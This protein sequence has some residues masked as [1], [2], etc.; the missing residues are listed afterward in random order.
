MGEDPL[1][2][3][4]RVDDATN[5]LACLEVHK[6][7]VMPRRHIVHHLTNDYDMERRALLRRRDIPRDELE[8]ILRDQF[9]ERQA[10]KPVARQNALYAGT[11]GCGGQGAGGN[12]GS[13]RGNRSRGSRGGD[14]G[15]KASEVHL[16]QSGAAI[17]WQQRGFLSPVSASDEMLSL[18][19]ARPPAQRVHC[20]DNIEPE[21]QH[22]YSWP[23]QHCYGRTA[24]STAELCWSISLYVDHGT[25]VLIFFRWTAAPT[26]IYDMFSAVREV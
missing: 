9:A 22:Q 26:A 15:G 4:D 19:S 6:T 8:E 24:T 21:P 7:E 25:D 3:I 5:M 11:Q 17:Q 10:A 23:G 1:V 18:Q 13:R 12:G 2:W 20:D 14:R 16:H